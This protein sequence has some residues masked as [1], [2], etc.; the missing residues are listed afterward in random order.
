MPA[1]SRII[2]VGKADSRTAG[3]T[4]TTDAAQAWS[5]C[6]IADDL[7]DTTVGIDGTID[8]RPVDG[9]VTSEIKLQIACLKTWAEL[10]KHHAGFNLVANL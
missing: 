6:K 1:Q 4:V 3:L 10:T 8:F 2:D 9:I 5:I 7:Y